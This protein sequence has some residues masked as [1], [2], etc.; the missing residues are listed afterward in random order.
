M[1]AC[2]LNL[3]IC[4]AVLLACSESF[5]LPNSGKALDPSRCPQGYEGCLGPGKICV[6]QVLAR[7]PTQDDLC[8]PPMRQAARAGPWARQPAA[9]LPP[10]AMPQVGVPAR[11]PLLQPQ[12]WAPGVLAA[13]SRVK[14]HYA[15]LNCCCVCMM[16]IVLCVAGH[17]VSICKSSS[18]W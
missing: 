2:N 11:P 9:P 10:Q 7:V 4:L 18:R 8:P 3:L 14:A 5:G 15:M 17:I 1:P 12:D 16:P 13:I 6:V